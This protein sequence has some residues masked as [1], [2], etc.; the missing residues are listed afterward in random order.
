[1]ASC[2][3]TLARCWSSASKIAGPRG[4]LFPLVRT[5]TK[6]LSYSGDAMKHTAIGLMLVGAFLLLLQSDILARGGGGGGGGGGRGGGGGGGGGGAARRPFAGG[7]W[8]RRAQPAP[9]TGGGA[10]RPAAGGRGGATRPAARRRGQLCGRRPSFRRS[11]AQLPRCPAPGRGRGAGA[12]AARPGGAAAD[13]LQ[14]GGPGAAQLPAGGGAKTGVAG[15][16]GAAAKT[17]AVA[18]KTGAGA[19]AGKVLPANAWPTTGPRR[20]E[21]RQELQGNRQSAAIEVRNQVTTTIPWR[22]SGAIIPAGQRCVSLGP[23][24]GP[25]GR[26]GRM[27]RLGNGR[28]D[29]PTPTATTSTTGRPGLLR[30][31]A[32]C[33]G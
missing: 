20:V 27:V 2:C 23:S 15:K 18:G 10:T 13:F 19:A 33:D 28:G 6:P 17:G 8:R 4:V 24:A 32:G 7:E 16:T 3:R 31:P 22:T 29:L 11:V 14:H 26:A 30:R 1:M 25:P 21:N 5:V 12:G 9:S